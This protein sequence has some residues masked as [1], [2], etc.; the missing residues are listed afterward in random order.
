MQTEAAVIARRGCPDPIASQIAYR[1]AGRPVCV[2]TATL[3]HAARP[4]IEALTGRTLEALRWEI[5]ARQTVEDPDK[6]DP[7]L[8]LRALEL[9]RA[10]A[11]DVTAIEDEER[12]TVAA[13]AAGITNSH[14][15]DGPRMALEWLEL[16]S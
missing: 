5:S 8:Y 6:P 16:L 15:I 7:S 4:M 13:R 11:A 2:V 12:G 3:E 9:L 14:L 10:D 1:A